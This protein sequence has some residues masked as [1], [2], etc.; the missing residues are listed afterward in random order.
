MYQIN[1]CD[2]QYYPIRVAARTKSPKRLEKIKAKLQQQGF[3]VGVMM[4]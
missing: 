3:I 2:A 4:S 1:I